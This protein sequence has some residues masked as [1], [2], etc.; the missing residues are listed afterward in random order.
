MKTIAGL[1][2]TETGI[3]IE[4]PFVENPS[5]KK[6]IPEATFTGEFLEL[7]KRIIKAR[8]AH[9]YRRLHSN[10]ANA[11]HVTPDMI[12]WEGGHFNV[13]VWEELELALELDDAR[14]LNTI[15]CQ[16]II[17]AM[18]A[19]EVGNWAY[20]YD[21]TTWTRFDKGDKH[22]TQEFRNF[23]TEQILVGMRPTPVF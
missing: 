14:K 7:A 10:L 23:I 22:I 5:V 15:Q 1:M 17:R 20:D 6:M 16:Q 11:K 4:R 8:M 12:A 18:L 19:D 2:F 3:V 13:N 9:C 21:T